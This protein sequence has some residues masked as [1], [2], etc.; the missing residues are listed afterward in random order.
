MK[1]SLNILTSRMLSSNDPHRD[2]NIL[3][4]CPCHYTAYDESDIYSRGTINGFLYTK[5]MSFTF[6]DHGYMMDIESTHIPF[7]MSQEH[8]YYR[9][10]TILVFS[11]HRWVLYDSIITFQ[12]LPTTIEFYTSM[13]HGY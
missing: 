9:M 3:E 12:Y 11:V 1:G 2:M 8:V 4:T 13:I 10:L 5:I 7:S 6:M